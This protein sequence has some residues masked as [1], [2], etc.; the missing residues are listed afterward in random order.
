MSDN[1]LQHLREQI[2]DLDN[3][4]I[5]VLNKRFKITDAVAEY[6]NAHNLSILDADREQQVLDRMKQRSQHPALTGCIA[7]LY[8]TIA[9]ANR[10]YREQ[11][12]SNLKK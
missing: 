4:L 12:I 8:A 9:K 2:D 6:K 7:L 1:T 10:D 5:D 11:Q 3:Q